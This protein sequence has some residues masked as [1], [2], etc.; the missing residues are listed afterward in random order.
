MYPGGADFMKFVVSLIVGAICALAPLSASAALVTSISGTVVPMPAVDYFGPGP[1]AFGPGITWSSDNAANQGGSVFG[2]TGGYNF[3]S[4]GF[5]DAGVGPMAGVN[6]S[7]AFYG[8]ANTMTFSFD[9]PQ[10]GVGGF[11]NYYPDSNDPAV[12]SVYDENMVLIESSVLSFST[13]GGNNSGQFYGFQEGSA[14]IK[15]FTLSDAYIGITN[16]TITDVNAVP[17]PASVV[18]L[19]L[20]GIGTGLA[21]WRRRRAA[22]A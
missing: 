18:L 11:I 7:A 10:S 19:G 2:Y 12:I 20:G 1:Q 14:V 9:T 3:G 13:G 5:W 8:T 22:T 15:Y 4:N 17:E 21:A 6:S 16:L